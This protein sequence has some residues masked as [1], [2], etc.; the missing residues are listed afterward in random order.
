MVFD[1]EEQRDAW[2]LDPLVHHCNHGSYGAVPSTVRD[3]QRAVQD[4]VQK[5]PV[6]FFAREAQDQ[7]AAARAKIAAFLGQRPEQIALVR[8]ATE[9]ASTTLRG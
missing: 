8:N 6:R 1:L 5:N 9:A 3:L 2:T 7:V 4:H